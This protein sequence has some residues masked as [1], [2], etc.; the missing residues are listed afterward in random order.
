MKLGS[1]IRSAVAELGQVILDLAS[2]EGLCFFALVAVVDG[3]HAGF[4]AERDEQTDRDGEEVQKEVTGAVNSVFGGVDVEHTP[5]LGF[6][7]A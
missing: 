2:D 5:A 6:S 4:E 3:F 1:G 7:L